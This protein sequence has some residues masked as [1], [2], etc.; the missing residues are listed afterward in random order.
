MKLRSDTNQQGFSLIG[1]LLSLSMLGLIGLL[2]VRGGSSVVEYW[3]VSKTISAAKAVSKTPAEVRVMF[4]KLAAAGYI[5]SIEGR[6]LRIDG[7][8]NN[9]EVHF[10]YQK[11]IPLIGPTSL[12]IDYQGSSASGA[13]TNKPAR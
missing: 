6:D 4:D 1:M 5:D 8:G 10:S 13:A 2:A 3:A 7:V 11:K 9:M 12:L